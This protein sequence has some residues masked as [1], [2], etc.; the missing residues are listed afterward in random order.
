MDHLENAY[1]I[2]FLSALSDPN[3]YF[4]LPFVIFQYRDKIIKKL[5]KCQFFFSLYRIFKHESVI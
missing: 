5:Q 2:V 1:P 3:V 4:T